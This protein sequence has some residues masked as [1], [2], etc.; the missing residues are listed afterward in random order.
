MRTQKGSLM[1]EVI[2]VLG[3]IALITPVLFRQIARRNEDIVAMQV[4]SEMRAV[5]DALAAYIQAYEQTIAQDCKEED[6]PDDRL[7]VNGSYVAVDDE[8]LC[9]DGDDIEDKVLEFYAGGLDAGEAMMNDYWFGVYGYTVPAK[10]GEDEDE[11]VY[12]PVLY[13]VVY[14]KVSEETLRMASKIAGLIGL[15]GG[16]VLSAGENVRGLDVDD[17]DYRLDK[18]SAVGVQAAWVLPVPADRIDVNTVVAVTSFDDA[19]NTAILKDVKLEHFTGETMQATT[20]TSSRMAVSDLLS[21]GGENCIIDAQDPTVQV[22][23]WGENGPTDEKG[24]QLICAPLFEVNAEDGVVRLAGVLT[25]GNC[26]TLTKK[27]DCEAAAYCTWDAKAKVGEDKTGVC[28]A[29]HKIDLSAEGISSMHDIKLTSRGGAK[30]SDL[31]PTYSLKGV[32]HL[33]KTLVTDMR[34][35]KTF[36]LKSFD[37]GSAGTKALVVVPTSVR[38][39]TTSV[40]GTSAHSHIVAVGFDDALMDELDSTDSLSV[41]LGDGLMEAI[42]YKYCVFEDDTAS[43]E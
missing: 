8:I 10:K 3:L 31:L 11:D 30:L 28:E 5:K 9:R 40:S 14:Q 43:A 33:E 18:K 17:D 7:F 39:D 4:A 15:D 42:V 26:A 12:R 25:K 23:G 24:N 21:V 1:I 16:V 38:V 35:D 37:C 19:T 6:N 36:T 13:G 20:S 22:V 34:L 2:A 32:E 41:T 27:D 29:R